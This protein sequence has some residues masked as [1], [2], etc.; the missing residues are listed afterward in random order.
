VSGEGPGVR[1]ADQ[2]ARIEAE[3][4]RC[5]ALYRELLSIGAVA[6]AAGLTPRRVARRLREAGVSPLVLRVEGAVQ[7]YAELRDV[8]A[9]ATRLRVS[10]T[11]VRNRLFSG[12]VLGLLEEMPAPTGDDL[13]GCSGRRVSSAAQA[14]TVALYAELRSL[15]AVGA[16]LGISQEAVRLRLR[17]AGVDTARRGTITA[18]ERAE[19]VRLYGV[20]KSVSRVAAESGRSELTVRRVLRASGV[21]PDDGLRLDIGRVER[22]RLGEARRLGEAKVIARLYER[23]HTQ[24]AVAHALGISQALVSRRLALLNIRPGR[25]NFPRRGPEPVEIARLR[26]YFDSGLSARRAALR[27]GIPYRT[28]LRWLHRDGAEITARPGRGRPLTV[29]SLAHTYARFRETYNAD[30]VARELGRSRRTINRQLHSIQLALAKHAEGSSKEAALDV[31]PPDQPPSGL[32]IWVNPSDVVFAEVSSL[33]DLE[34]SPR[35]GFLCPLCGQRYWGRW[36]ISQHLHKPHIRCREAGCTKI[37]V[38]GGL[39]SHR[40]NVHGGRAELEALKRRKPSGGA[41]A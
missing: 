23:L 5:I 26:A 32:P 35:G 36:A 28:A 9:V 4:A 33:R 16:R 14:E 18:E 10:E 20:V 25:G 12:V 17:K 37:V 11:V 7:L 1:R 6:A 8:R 3:T 21:Q 41:A 34:R 15:R 22:Q 13:R 27:A 40:W 39:T 29:E 38:V 31:L 19:L 24:V 2:R 30:E